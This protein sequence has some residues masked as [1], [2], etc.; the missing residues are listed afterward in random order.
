[1]EVPNNSTFY[2]A[3]EMSYWESEPRRSHLTMQ[4]ASLRT[5]IILVANTEF[6]PLKVSALWKKESNGMKLY[7]KFPVR[8]TLSCKT[9][10]KQ[11]QPAGPSRRA[12]ASCEEVGQDI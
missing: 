3:L 1:M 7:S 6:N 5:A 4:T 8:C 12:A 10:P 9:K 11:Q 2:K